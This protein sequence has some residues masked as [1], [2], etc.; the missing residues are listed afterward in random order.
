[1]SVAAEDILK[2]GS[3][4]ET[5]AALTDQVRKNP[6]DA[7]GRIFIFQMYCVLGAWEKALTQL[8]VCGELDAGTL[9]MVQTYR[10]AIACEMMREKV[11]AGKKAP[12]V[13]GQPEN[14]IALLIQAL[15]PAARGDGAAAAA[16]REKAF[17]DAPAIDG[18][19]NGEPFAWVADADSRLGPVCELILNGKYYWAPFSNIK[20][21]QIEEPTDLRDRVWTPANIMFATGGESVA[22][23]PTRYPGAGAS[24]SDDVRLA[25]LTDW[26]DIGAETY[27]G[28]GQKLFATDGGDFGVM[29][30]RALDLNLPEPEEMP[31]DEAEAE[32]KDG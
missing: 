24:D 28:A 8:K 7:R 15:E 5:M 27:L 6:A 10:E 13:F 30:I 4:A 16:L 9:S 20:R 11:F 2:T 21:I 19:L 31:E 23:I 25:R 3:I 12:L 32:V 22:F 14:W 18:T 26:Q 1:M 17:K 29:D